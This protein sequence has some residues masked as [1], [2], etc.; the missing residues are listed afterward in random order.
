M[1][2]SIFRQRFYLLI[3]LSL[4]CF[5][6]VDESINECIT[7]EN[8]YTQ[9]LHV[10]QECVQGKWEWYASYGG[11]VG[12]S[13]PKNTFV[14]IQE[15]HFTITNERGQRTTYFT[16][17][18]KTLPDGNVTWVMW[19]KEREAGIWAFPTISNDSLSVA[20]A[21]GNEYLYYRVGNLF[22]KVR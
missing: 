12:I 13:Y 15:D 8:L 18:K 14:D 2:K 5:G 11:Y 9:P 4:L 20:S 16:W 17:E 19:D 22:V 3:L 7:I 1:E 21:T 6:C 10:I